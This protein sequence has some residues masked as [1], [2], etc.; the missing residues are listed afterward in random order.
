M[1]MLHHLVVILVG[2]VRVLREDDSPEEVAIT[3]DVLG[4]LE[5]IWQVVQDTFKFSYILHRLS[6]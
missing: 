2:P 1:V 3:E 5:L 4:I 6:C